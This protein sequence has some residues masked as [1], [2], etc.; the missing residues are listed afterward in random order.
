MKGERYGEG[1][2]TYGKREGEAKEMWRGGKKRE[3]QCIRESL[4]SK[5]EK[6]YYS[7][8]GIFLG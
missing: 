4:T 2:K 6:V 5:F 1:R 8:K 3:E 7:E